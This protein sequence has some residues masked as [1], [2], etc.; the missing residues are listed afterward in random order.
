M[1]IFAVWMVVIA[2]EL[3]TPPAIKPASWTMRSVCVD[4]IGGKWVPD[5]EK[6]NKKC[7]L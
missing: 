2:V 1:E 3:V 7:E 4:G 5:L 6:G